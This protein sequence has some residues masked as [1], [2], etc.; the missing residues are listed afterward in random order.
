MF[1]TTKNAE[2]IRSAEHF[3][4]ICKEQSPFFGLAMLLDSGYG[5]ED[6]LKVL[7]QLTPRKT[8]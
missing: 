8:A 7:K 2:Y 4:N 5:R 6:M 3:E 1:G